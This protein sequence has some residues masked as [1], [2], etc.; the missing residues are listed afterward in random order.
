MLCRLLISRRFSPILCAESSRPS[1]YPKKT[2]ISNKGKK[3]G[4]LRLG[5]LFLAEERKVTNRDDEVEY[6]TDPEPGVG[7]AVQVRGQVGEGWARAS[8]VQS[9][10]TGNDGADRTDN[11]RCDE[12]PGNMC[13]DHCLKKQHANTDTLDQVK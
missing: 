8:A 6:E 12:C 2:I 3:E 7:E 1:P 13:S 10:G 11:L 4:P 9:I 5:E